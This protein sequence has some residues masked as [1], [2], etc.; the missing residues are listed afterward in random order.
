MYSSNYVCNEQ[1]IA[2]DGSISKEVGL[3]TG[4]RRKKSD[5]SL[6]YTYLF[7]D[8]EPHTRMHLLPK[9]CSR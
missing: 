2:G 4:N 3:I 1:G 8:C 5:F 9:N 7:L 6:A